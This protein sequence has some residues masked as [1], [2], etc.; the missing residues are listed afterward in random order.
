MTISTE[1]FMHKPVD[2]IRVTEENIEQVAAWCHGEVKVYYGFENG[3]LSEN[4]GKNYIELK[5]S[6]PTGRRNAKAFSG[7]WIVTVKGSFK[8]YNNRAFGETFNPAP[9]DEHIQLLLSMMVANVM[10]MAFSEE[11]TDDQ[12]TAELIRII[13]GS[14]SEILDLL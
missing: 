3:I 4:S 10:K 2:A 6:H 7:D 12:K 9:D 5:V 8:V 11:M 13:E 14:S 1:R